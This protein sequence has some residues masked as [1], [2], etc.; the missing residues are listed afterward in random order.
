MPLII[1]PAMP[2]SGKIKVKGGKNIEYYEIAVRQFQQ[3]ILPPGMPPTT[4]W[5][6]GSVNHPGSFN[7]HGGHTNAE[8]DG[9]AEAW[10]LPAAG[11]IPAGLA[12]EGTWY[13]SF[14]TQFQN[15]TGVTWA[16]GSAVSQY[17]NNQYATTM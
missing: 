5:S 7:L 10:Y 2:R 14:K 11:N 17:D 13:A 15:Q 16:P 12:T 4:V 1:P 8:S 9:Y 6:Y 3:Q